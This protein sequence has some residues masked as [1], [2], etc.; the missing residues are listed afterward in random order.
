MALLCV[1]SEEIRGEKNKKS[2]Q[3]VHQ[4]LRYVYNTHPYNVAIV[5]HSTITLHQGTKHVTAHMQAE[6]DLNSF[7]RGF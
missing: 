2:Q 4:E 1:W 6:L 7:A 3:V 5:R